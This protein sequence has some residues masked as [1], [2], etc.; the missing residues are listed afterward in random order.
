MDAFVLWNSCTKLVKPV[1]SLGRT[2]EISTGIPSGCESPGLNPVPALQGRGL[3]EGK[4]VAPVI[5]WR[6]R[7]CLVGV[8][9]VRR[10]GAAFTWAR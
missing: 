4:K 9:R 3:L 7:V 5:D 6:Y 2:V 8:R 10:S 1:E